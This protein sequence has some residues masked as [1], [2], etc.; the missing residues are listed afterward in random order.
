MTSIEK[1][2]RL[3]IQMDKYLESLACFTQEKK[4]QEFAVS[5]MERLVVYG[6]QHAAW[7]LGMAY[8]GKSME[9]IFYHSH[10]GAKLRKALNDSIK[11]EEEAARRAVAGAEAAGKKVYTKE[12][13]INEVNKVI[14]SYVQAVKD[15][16][17][18]QNN[19]NYRYD[20]LTLNALEFRAGMATPSQILDF[21]NAC[22]DRWEDHKEGTER[23]VRAAR[24]HVRS[25]DNALVIGEDL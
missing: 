25:R 17:E 24:D 10:C 6:I 20:S 21:R 16:K 11:K 2:N 19:K 4:G 1:H 3:K 12:Q 14:Q 7:M 8:Q 18:T 5:I 22:R 15:F 23:L 9:E 13:F